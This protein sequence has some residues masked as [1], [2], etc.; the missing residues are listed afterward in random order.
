MDSCAHAFRRQVDE[1][2][3]RRL[4][5]RRAVP[6]EAQPDLTRARVDMKHL[7]R[8]AKQRLLSFLSSHGHR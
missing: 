5:N 6:Q 8:R 1:L 4:L 2:V 3:T 7:Q